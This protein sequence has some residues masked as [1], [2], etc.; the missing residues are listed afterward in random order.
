MV[1][2]EEDRLLQAHACGLMCLSSGRSL[3]LCPDRDRLV[4]RK[5]PTVV[6]CA[7]VVFKV[8]FDADEEIKALSPAELQTFSMNQISKRCL[9]AFVQTSN[10][11][12]GDIDFSASC[13]D[14]SMH[15]TDCSEE[16]VQGM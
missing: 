9:K 14:I 13:H 2:P 8:A 16:I 1:V 3:D 7:C 5:V 6:I 4:G 12:Y 10:K 11:L 15:Q